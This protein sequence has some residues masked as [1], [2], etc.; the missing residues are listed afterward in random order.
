MQNIMHIGFCANVHVQ[1]HIFLRLSD[2]R[3]AQKKHLQA[4][5]VRAPQSQPWNFAGK[6]ELFLYRV[7]SLSKQ[8]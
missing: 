8:L 3:D 6:L 4:L 7:E 5:K 1:N 2:L